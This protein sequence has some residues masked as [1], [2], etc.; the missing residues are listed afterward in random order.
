MIRHCSLLLAVFVCLALLPARADAAAQPDYPAQWPASDVVFTVPFNPGSETDQ[1]FSLVRDAFG[2]KTGKTM[3]ARHVAGKAGAHA[4][5]R[6]IDDAPDGSVLTAV[7]LPDAYL[8]M[9]QPDSGVNLDAMAICH[10]IASMPATLWTSSP[11]A[12]AA[13]TDIPNAA[14]NGNFMIAGPGSYSAGQLA[15]RALDRQLG[16]RTLYI[17]YTGTVTAAKAALNREAHLFWGYSVRVT[18]PGLEQAVFKPLA[19]A[20]ANRLP[21][22]PEAPTFKEL[23]LAVEESVSIGIAVPADTPEITRE[24]ITEY[25]SALAN[26]PSFL[27]K[28]SALGFVPQNIGMRDMPAFLAAMKQA[29]NGKAEDFS[30]A[31]Q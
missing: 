11:D 13:V 6:M 4:W 27:A 7:V 22:L 12:F 19:V 20:A 25:F 3:T 18:V 15:A 23:G 31:E 10:I 8:R 9:L 17:P 2:A 30:L 28:L 26:E 16:I 14:A 24:E 1:L 29:A 5:A 21:A